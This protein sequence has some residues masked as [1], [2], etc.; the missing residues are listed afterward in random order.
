MCSTSI[1]NFN[2]HLQQYDWLPL[3]FVLHKYPPRLRNLF[4]YRSTNRII[5]RT[6]FTQYNSPMSLTIK[7]LDIT[8]A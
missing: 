2:T 1:N 7:L 8:A 4:S 5:L 6:I 3:S